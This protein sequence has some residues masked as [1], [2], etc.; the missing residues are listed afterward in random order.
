MT[1]T[2]AVATSTAQNGET[3]IAVAVIFFVFMS[4]MVVGMVCLA[5]SSG[6]KKA[7]YQ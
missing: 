5:T 7:F 4:F 2:Q 1:T 6:G 3:V